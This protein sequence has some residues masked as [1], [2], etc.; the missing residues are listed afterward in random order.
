[1]IKSNRVPN[2]T[3]DDDLRCL[4]SS[5]QDKRSIR[6]QEL[7]LWN[8]KKSD[9]YLARRRV[10]CCLTQAGWVS[11]FHARSTIAC[12]RELCK[13]QSCIN[14]GHGSL[15]I[16]AP[17]DVEYD[18]VAHKE[19]ALPPVCTHSSFFCVQLSKWSVG[20]GSLTPQIQGSL[21]PEYQRLSICSIGRHNLFPFI[22]EEQ[23]DLCHTFPPGKQCTK[24]KMRRL[25]AWSARCPPEQMSTAI[26]KVWRN[27]V[28]T[29]ILWTLYI[30]LYRCI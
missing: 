23:P 9:R 15:S 6:P 29:I 2:K 26:Y 10:G 1:M 22:G 25:Q 28:G 13:Q 18:P 24:V 5:Q 14:L 12:T 16:S 21:N 3:H 8:R 27:T 7:P 11:P 19:H 30:L 4:K 20:K 17:V